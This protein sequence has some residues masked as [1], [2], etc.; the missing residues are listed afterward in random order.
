MI[1]NIHDSY[2]RDDKDRDPSEKTDSGENKAGKDQCGWDSAMRTTCDGTS[3]SSRSVP[4]TK[5]TKVAADTEAIHKKFNPY[6]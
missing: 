4:R 1:V 3:V 5:S 6:F 2:Q